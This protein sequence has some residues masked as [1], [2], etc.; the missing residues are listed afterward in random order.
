M[1]IIDFEGEPRRSLAERREKTSPLRD[2]AGMLRSFDYASAT[3]LARH[4]ENHGSLGEAAVSRADDWLEAT[5][6]AFL[7]AYTTGIAGSGILPDD[8]AV[9]RDLIEFFVM[10][11]AVYEIGYELANRPNWI[12]IPL[13]GAIALLAD[14]AAS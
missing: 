5:N 6:S 2:V 13:D 11:K 12:G 8:E 4:A 3:A 14:D 7:S 9:A 10:Q 1:L